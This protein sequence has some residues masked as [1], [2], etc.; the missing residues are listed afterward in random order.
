MRGIAPPRPFTDIGA[1]SA[2]VLCRPETAT[3]TGSPNG[4]AATTGS[5]VTTPAQA[6]PV[7]SHQMRDAIDHAYAPVEL[8]VAEDLLREGEYRSDG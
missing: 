1:A 6:D 2:P 3:S 8:E 7:A 5:P 4:Q